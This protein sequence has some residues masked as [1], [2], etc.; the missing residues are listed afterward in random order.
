[1]KTRPP[2]LKNW[3]EIEVSRKS[4]SGEKYV[5]SFANA[6][7]LSRLNILHI[8]LPPG[9]RSGAPGASRDAEEFVFVLEGTPDLWIDGHLH[10]LREGDGAAFNDR[11][12]I[13]HTLV[14]NT[15]TEVRL[16]VFGEGARAFSQFACPLPADAATNE[17]LRKAA[18][19]W[20]DAP[21]RKLGPNTAKPGDTRGVKRTRPSYVNSWRDI[22]EKDTGGYPRSTE[23]HGIDALFGRRARFSRIGIHFE[24]LPAGR[25]TSWPHAERDEEEFVYVVA[26]E[27]Q[28]WINGH[29]HTMAEGDFVGFESRTDITHVIINNSDAEALLLVGA[30][31][32]RSRNQF[33]YPFHPHRDK[34]TG[35]LFWAD[36]PKLKL[37]PHDGL[38][39]ALR[40]RLPKA[41]RRN[42]VIANRAAMKLKPAKR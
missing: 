42:A 22:L 18:R 28:C 17:Q 37:G 40:T 36:H 21:Q 27:V 23:K 38:P 26:G 3:R 24:I 4:P 6:S 9:T 19:L 35:E 14:N 34:E 12:G 41:A 39:D 15:D 11:T 30:E 13:A 5:A 33:W 7:G 1:M 25:R 32:A 2:F 16:F 10:R 31:A 8:R 29:L 20:Q